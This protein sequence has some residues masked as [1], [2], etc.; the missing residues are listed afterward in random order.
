MLTFPFDKKDR[1][2]IDSYFSRV[3]WLAMIMGDL[4]SC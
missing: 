3:V 1:V 2:S 4:R